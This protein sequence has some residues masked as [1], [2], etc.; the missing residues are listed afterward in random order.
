MPDNAEHFTQSGPHGIRYDFND[1]CRI[2]CPQ[3]AL[4]RLVLKDEDTG[5]ILFEHTFEGGTVQSA[6][7]SFVRFHLDIWRDGAHVFAH[8][9]NPKG[10]AVRI[11]MRLGALGDQLAWMGQV[12][13]FQTVNGCALTCIM[14]ASVAA[15]LA[16]SYPEMR[17]ML[18][19]EADETRYYATY[20]VCIFYNDDRGL[21]QPVDYRLAG[22]YGNAAHI[23]GLEP[24]EYRPRLPVVDEQRPIKEPY[25]CIAVQAS[26]LAKYWNNP[27]GWQEVV[28][29]LKEAGYRVICIDQ[30]PINGKDLS[31]IPMPHGA[32]DQTG[33]RPLQERAWWL[34]HAA[35]FVGLSS[36]LS[37]LAWAA[38]CP[39]VMISGFTQPFNEFHTEWRVIN[40]NVCNGCANDVRCRFDAQDFFWCPRH[41]GEQQAFECTKLILPEQVI[42]TIQNLQRRLHV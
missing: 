23:L 31:W 32:E 38:H 34:Q 20:K 35:F 18:P 16:P 40:R 24:Q 10:Q 8:K 42:K 3:G 36:G 6:R 5:N 33:N 29:F 41:K 15:L 17:I 25:V 12:E 27:Y 13:R 39:V 26:G 1:G 19:D 37:W 2:F 21:H 11:D 7:R 14:T 4:W 9:F 28:T 22:L 30:K